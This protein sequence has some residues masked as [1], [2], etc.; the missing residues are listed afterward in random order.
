MENNQSTEH[1][2]VITFF[3]LI[4]VFSLP[5]YVLC[6]MASRNIILQNEIIPA[7]VAIF[8]FVPLLAALLITAKRILPIH[9]CHEC[10]KNVSYSSLKI[11]FSSFFVSAD[12]RNLPPL[13]SYIFLNKNL[14]NTFNIIFI[15]AIFFSCV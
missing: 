9:I 8:A 7:I 2:S 10:S 14:L 4:F 12:I 1:R 11:P 13:I 5:F 3:I 15:D 6:F